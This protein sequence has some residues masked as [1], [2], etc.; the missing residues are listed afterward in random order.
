MPKPGGIGGTGGGLGFRMTAPEMCLGS[1]LEAI[2][3]S[4]Q[5]GQGQKADLSQQR[6]GCNLDQMR[7]VT[8]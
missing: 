3:S 6:K 2:G 4:Y 1:G 8:D 5:K 7:H